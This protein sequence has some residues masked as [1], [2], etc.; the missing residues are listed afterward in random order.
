MSEKRFNNLWL[1]VADNEQSPNGLFK[2]V[3]DRYAEPQRRYHTFDH[4]VHC[5]DQA[6]LVADAIPNANAVEL[7]IWFHDVIYEI[8]ACDNERQSANWFRQCAEGHLSAETIED[9]DRLIM[10]TVHSHMPERDDEAYMVDI[11]LSSFGLPWDKFKTDSLAVREE[12]PHLSDN[13]Y[14]AS[15]RRFLE[16]LLA[17]PAIY[18]T[19]FFNERYDSVARQN[20]VQYL[21]EL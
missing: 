15:Q 17:R 1:S 19:T 12:N 21:D 6:D 11:D 20:I 9:V 4:I 13:E 7:A 3:V 10:A 2:E 14:N 18:S 8:Q 5:L 16:R